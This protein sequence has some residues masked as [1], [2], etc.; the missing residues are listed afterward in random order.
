MLFV[1]DL[2]S[3]DFIRLFLD[4]SD[5]FVT[6]LLSYHGLHEPVVVSQDTEFAGSHIE[7]VNELTS[8]LGNLCID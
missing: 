2:A 6:K 1:V 5:V 7:L 3:F 8:F 4:R